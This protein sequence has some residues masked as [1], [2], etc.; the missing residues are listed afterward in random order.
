MKTYVTYGFMMALGGLLLNLALYFLGFHSEVEKFGTAQWIGGL[1]GLAIVVVLIVL[2]TKARRNEVPLSEEF[3]YGR[4][5]GAGVMIVLFG[6]LFGVVVNIVYMKF[7]NPGMADLIV[8]VQSAKFE[9]KGMSGAQ[10]E[11]AEKFTRMM[12]GPIISSIFNFFGGMIIGTIISLITAAF[13]K[14]SA[15][16]EPPPVTA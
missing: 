10:L 11:Q 15:S 7:I 6:A 5:L 16:A 3:G 2:G 14:R 1:G 12:T 9:A 4:A 13:L 8:Q